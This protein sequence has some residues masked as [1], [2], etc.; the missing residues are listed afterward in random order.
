MIKINI[1]GDICITQPYLFDDLFSE[2]IISIFEESD[3]NILNLEC[4]IIDNDRTNKIIKTGPHLHTTREIMA[5]LMKL[6]TN[7]VT[8]ANNHILDYG[9]EGLENTLERCLQDQISTVGAGASLEEAIKPIIIEKDG[10]HIGIINF[11]E[12][13]WSIA[14]KTSPGANP[15]NTIDNFNQIKELRNKADI[16]IVIIHGGHEYY[17][18]PSPRMV[19]QYRFFAEN[20]ADAVIGHHP[21]CIGGYEIYNNVP[22]FYS[23]GNFLFTLNSIYEDWYT[24]LLLQLI[25][26]K[27]NKINFTLLPVR[28]NKVNFKLS[29]LHGDEKDH[30]L[31]LAEGYSNIIANDQLLFS[32]W[33][34][35][36]NEKSNY[37]L[38]VFSPINLLSNTK[39]RGLLKK[40]GVSK[41]FRRKSHYLTILNYIRC[42]SHLDISINAIKKYQKLKNENSHSQ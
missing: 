3:F 4:P 22:I 1:A 35:V 27:S 20:G 26:D 2:E 28:Q 34:E 37:Y 18:L 11:C 31:K 38:D 16:V 15:L 40:L 25:I 17:N 36:I 42:E 10:I 6:K 19:K 30:V 7:A 29:V 41:F 23:L 5:Q 33:E 39:I 13:E 9:A 12:N 32:K 8:L 24:G 21:H 14:T